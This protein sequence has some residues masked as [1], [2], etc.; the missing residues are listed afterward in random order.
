[1]LTSFYGVFKEKYERLKKDLEKELKRAK[2]DRRK[3][4]MKSHIKEIKD[5]KQTLKEMDESMGLHTCPK[6]GYK[7]K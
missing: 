6:C 7:L 3:D 2:S 5:L 1:M 4:W